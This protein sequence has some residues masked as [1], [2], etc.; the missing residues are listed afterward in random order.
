MD[1]PDLT[2]DR[3]RKAEDDIQQELLLTI[4]PAQPILDYLQGI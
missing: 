2:D 3:R 4:Y 1:K